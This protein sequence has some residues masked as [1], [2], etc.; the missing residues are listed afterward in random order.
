M[1]AGM[2]IADSARKRGFRDEDI[3]H[4]I[5]NYVRV[6][7]AQGDLELPLFIGPAYDGTMLEVGVIED[8]EDPRVV[9]CMEVRS[10]YWP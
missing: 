2:R 8:E 6:F 7:G 1:V 9:H 4:A 3:L 10:Q 5:R